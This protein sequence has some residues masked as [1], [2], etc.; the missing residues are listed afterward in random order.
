MAKP[1][2][3]RVVVNLAGGGHQNVRVNRER[4]SDYLQNLYAGVCSAWQAESA[5]H[6]VEMESKDEAGGIY[7][8]VFRAA[9]VIGF[10]TYPERPPLTQEQVDIQRRTLELME[11]AQR[12][13]EEWREGEDGEG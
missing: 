10:Y 12:R 3:Y 4:M 2:W 8:H 9:E 5:K 7:V 13:G 1:E 11:K 6:F